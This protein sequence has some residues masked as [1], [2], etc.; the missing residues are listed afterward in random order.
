MDYYLFSDSAFFSNS[1]QDNFN[2]IGLITLEVLEKER[3]SRISIGDFYF[4]SVT[5]SHE[6]KDN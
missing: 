4:L 6:T 1:F 5:K 3:N 2:I